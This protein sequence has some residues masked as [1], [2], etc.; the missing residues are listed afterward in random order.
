MS[1]LDILLLLL[2]AAVLALAVRSLW[3]ARKKG[4]CQG[5]CAGCPGCGYRR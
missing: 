2:M 1:I 3:K 5:D 4:G